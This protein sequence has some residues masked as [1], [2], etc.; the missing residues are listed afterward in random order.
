MYGK[1]S[2][3]KL[4][5]T[6]HVQ[7]RVGCRVRKLKKTVCGLGGKRKLT[8]AL[9]DHLQNYYGIAIRANV[10]LPV[11]FIA[12]LPTSIRDM[13]FAHLDRTA[14]VGTEGSKHSAKGSMCAKVGF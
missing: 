12:A 3:Q 9:I 14:G 7:K 13:G 2:A 5:C 8:D 11:F 1:D 10:A 4:E 6:G